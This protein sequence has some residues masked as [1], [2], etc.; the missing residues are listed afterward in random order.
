MSLDLFLSSYYQRPKHRGY[1]V[2]ASIDNLLI[3]EVLLQVGFA[4]MDLISEPDLY[5]KS[6]NRASWLA[7]SSLSLIGHSG[8]FGWQLE[9]TPL[10]VIRNGCLIVRTPRMVQRWLSAWC[11]TFTLFSRLLCLATL[12]LIKSSLLVDGTLVSIF[13]IQTYWGNHW[14]DVASTQSFDVG[15]A[16]LVPHASS[17]A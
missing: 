1:Q 9:S 12:K 14:F 10:Y 11:S 13:D 17:K 4:L 6:P 8:S 2:I 5:C 15:V 3:D 7:S 16:A